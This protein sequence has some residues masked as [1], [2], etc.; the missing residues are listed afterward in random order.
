MCM[1]CSAQRVIFYNVERMVGVPSR[2]YSNIN[3]KGVS[4]EERHCRD[5][6][7]A[8]RAACAGSVGRIGIGSYSTGMVRVF[9]RLG[10]PLSVGNARQLSML[11]H[12]ALGDRSEHAG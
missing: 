2:D 12:R 8:V 3:K 7:R 4:D 5:D 1:G 11:N 10:V 6:S 9:R